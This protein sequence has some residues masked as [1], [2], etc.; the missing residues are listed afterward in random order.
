MLVQSSKARHDTLA[1]AKLPPGGGGEA[2]QERSSPGRR[3]I[4]A[5]GEEWAWSP[6]ATSIPLG[7][8]RR[9][10]DELPRDRDIVTICGTGA[11][12]EKAREVLDA[13]GFQAFNGG[14]YKDVLKVVGTT[15]TTKPSR[16]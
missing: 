8:L 11:R 14:A 1:N 16:S 6:G 12:A 7:T 9:H 3:S 4:E 2:A 15:G 10:L 5:R 13:E